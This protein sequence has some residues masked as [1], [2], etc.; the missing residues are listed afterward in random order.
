[1]TNMIKRPYQLLSDLV[2][3]EFDPSVGYARRVVNVSVTAD[4]TFN[5]GAVFYRAKGTDP[6]V[7]YSVVNNSS[8]LVTTNEFAVMIG[9]FYGYEIAPVTVLLA[10]SPQKLTVYKRGL[11]VLKDFTVKAA[12]LAN[13]SGMTDSNFASLCHLLEEQD[14]LVEVAGTVVRPNFV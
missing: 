8:Q 12:V 2:V 10:N 14:V 9:D 3:H 6:T 13:W 4:T 7:A 11:V 1:M 5:L